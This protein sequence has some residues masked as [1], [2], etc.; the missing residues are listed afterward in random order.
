MARS[1]LVA[2]IRW[3][4]PTILSE[5]PQHCGMERCVSLGAADL[6]DINV[7]LLRQL[8]AGLPARIHVEQLE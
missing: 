5:L 8:P 6:A 1:K 7:Q 4:L 3:H 2:N